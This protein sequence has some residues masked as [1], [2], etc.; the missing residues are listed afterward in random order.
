VQTNYTVQNFAWVGE[1]LTEFWI[2]G[3]NGVSRVRWDLKGQDL[4]NPT[5]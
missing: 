1:D 4:A 3:N 2:M 5:A